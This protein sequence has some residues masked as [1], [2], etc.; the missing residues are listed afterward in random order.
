MGSA[1]IMVVLGIILAKGIGFVREI[2]FSSAFGTGVYADIYFQ[3]FNIVNLIFAG[4]GVALSTLVIKN[5]NKPE[6]IGKEKAYV[7]SFLRK[8]ILSFT[9]VALLFVIFARPI[10]T[11]IILPGLAEEFV[12]LAVKQMYIMAPSLVFVV[13]AYIVSGV[14]QNEKVYFVTAIM[15]LPFNA[16]IIAGLLFKNPTLTSIAVITTFG[17][18]LH[19][20]ILLPSFF[21]KGYSFIKKSEKLTGK[22]HK[23]PEIMWIFISNMMYQLLFYTDRAFV[24]E[25]PGMASTFSYASNLFVIVASIFVVAMSTVFFPSISK[26]Y[27]EGN[28]DYINSLLRYMIT[29]MVAIFVPFLLVVG[30]FGTNIIC[31]VYERGDAFTHESTLAVAAILFIYSLG[32]LGYITQELFNKILYTAG[33]YKM[34]VFG[35]I[36]VILANLVTNIAIMKFCPKADFMNSGLGF[37]TALIAISSSFYLFCYALLISFSIKKVVG[38]Y[39]KKELLIDLVKVAVSSIGAFVV[40]FVFN[41]FLPE[42]THGKFSFIIPLCA[43]G[44]IYIAALYFSGVLMKLIKRKGTE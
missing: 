36:G 2:V 41:R 1:Y 4:I 42:L 29:V 19:I 34:C 37:E 8:S 11:N 22:K 16:V 26:N 3:V 32:I 38:A 24:S 25:T 21:K 10:V 6:N 40:Y 15:S 35:T 31:L 20:A 13:I 7:A 30:L 44:V 18:F 43:C 33:K 39:W 27:E 14:L 17:W 12:P 28:I 9:A 5:M 23:N